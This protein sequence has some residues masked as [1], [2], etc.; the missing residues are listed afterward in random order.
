MLPQV[1]I[2]L[3]TILACIYM[4]YI[5]ISLLQNV[6][7]LLVI[8]YIHTFIYIYYNVDI[9]TLIGTQPDNLMFAISY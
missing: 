2:R 1:V 8:T 9:V 5:H 4:I 6:R 3:K 7:G